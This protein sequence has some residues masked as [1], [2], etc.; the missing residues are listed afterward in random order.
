MHFNRSTVHCLLENH[1]GF[2]VPYLWNA[3]KI[4]NVKF[5]GC[6]F[7][8][9]FCSCYVLN[10]IVE[11]ACRSIFSSLWYWRLFDLFV[12]VFIMHRTIYSNYVNKCLEMF[13]LSA[14]QCATELEFSM[15]CYQTCAVYYYFVSLSSN[16]WVCFYKFLLIVFRLWSDIIAF[17]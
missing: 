7:R 4:V 1:I 15:Q 5:P 3:D 6:K 13:I 17:V 11:S 16:I 8:P 2:S 10:Y 9:L 12:E 14:Y